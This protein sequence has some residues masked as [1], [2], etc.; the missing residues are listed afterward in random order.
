M[1]CIYI[2]KTKDNTDFTDRPPAIYMLNAFIAIYLVSLYMID[3]EFERAPFR[4]RLHAVCVGNIVLRIWKC[5]AIASVQKCVAIANVRIV[6]THCAYV[7][8][9]WSRRTKRPIPSL[10]CVTQCSS[11]SSVFR[12]NSKWRPK[13][14]VCIKFTAVGL[15]SKRVWILFGFGMEIH[16]EFWRWKRYSGSKF[17]RVGP[18]D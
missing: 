7:V 11:N 4:R 18:M 8:G 12:I 16:F 2:R 6:G 13:K 5:V 9:K 17:I 3:A 15:I 1:L 10:L 14:V